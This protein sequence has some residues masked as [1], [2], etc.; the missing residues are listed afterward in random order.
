M[1]IIDW[2]HFSLLKVVIDSSAILFQI[3][4]QLAISGF[5][6]CGADGTQLSQLFVVRLKKYFNQSH[7][8]NSKAVMEVFSEPLLHT[9]GNET[10]IGLSSFYYEPKNTLL[11][12]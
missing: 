9:E 12:D 4:T 2:L 8:R 6:Y 10:G 1:D 3:K 7:L 5:T 11:C